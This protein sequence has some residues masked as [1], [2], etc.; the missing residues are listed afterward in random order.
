ML[1]YIV[2][3]LIL[4]LL[5]AGVWWWYDADQHKKC[6]EQCAMVGGDCS[7]KCTDMGYKPA[8]PG[9]VPD[10]EAAAK[11]RARMAM[12]RRKKYKGCGGAAALY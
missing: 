12:M 8:L 1:N 7:K 4:L 2:G 3:L 6:K 5:G 11:R 10:P 9:P